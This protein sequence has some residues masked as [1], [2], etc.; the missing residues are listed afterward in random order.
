M[1]SNPTEKKHAHI[2]NNNITSQNANREL[3][4]EIKKNSLKWNC[5]SFSEEPRQTQKIKN[6]RDSN[7]NFQLQ[8]A[9][10]DTLIVVG[11]IIV[12]FHSSPPPFLFAGSNRLPNK[13][14]SPSTSTR[15]VH[16]NGQIMVLQFLAVWVFP[17]S[18]EPALTSR[19]DFSNWQ[20]I[21]ISEWILN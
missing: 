8:K 16:T 10:G 15:E 17:T 6:K 11:P 2:S 19:G 4:R 13:G 14:T 18:S 5:C 20:S 12:Y 9:R 3:R 1:E 21:P 7:S